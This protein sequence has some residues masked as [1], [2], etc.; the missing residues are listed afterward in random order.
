MKAKSASLNLFHLEQGHHQEVCRW[1]DEDHRPEVLGSAPDIFISQRWVAPPAFA[2]ARPSGSLEYN[3]GEYV[4]LYWSAGEP[5]EIDAGFAMLRRR[6]V[7]AGRM[8][9]MRYIQ[10]PWNER[11]R[12]LSAHV[13]SDV[14]L[15]AEAM[16]CAPQNTGLMVVIS[17]LLASDAQHAFDD[18]TQSVYLPMVLEAGIFSA[19]LR[20]TVDPPGPVRR[21]VDFFY[22]DRPDPLAAYLEFRELSAD[23]KSAG[24]EFPGIDRVRTRVHEGIYRPSRGDDEFYA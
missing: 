13:R 21:T 6:L 22:T 19:A 9:L 24:E 3:G 4:N 8:S 15:S 14:T 12:P 18:W 23:W 1:H 7:P 10:M 5:A 16:T 17:Q 20:L 11:L 2:A